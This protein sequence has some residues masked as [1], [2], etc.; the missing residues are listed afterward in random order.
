MLVGTTVKDAL[1][2]WNRRECV[3]P[4]GIERDRCDHL[5]SL[6][7]R[8]PVVHRPVEVKLYLCN[9]TRGD[10]SADSDKATIPRRKVRART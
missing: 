4:T 10:Q 3:G 8:Q 7:S 5:R 2:D 9:L 6:R 1:G